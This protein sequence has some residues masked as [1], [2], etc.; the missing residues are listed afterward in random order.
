MKEINLNL[1]SV[2]VKAEVRELRCSY[3]RKMSTDI[4]HYNDIS[5]DMNRTIKKVFRQEIIKENRKKSIEKI[6][7]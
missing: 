4:S 7:D 5:E 2:E 1:T 3:T 6:F